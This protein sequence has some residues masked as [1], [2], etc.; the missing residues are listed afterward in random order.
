MRTTRSFREPPIMPGPVGRALAVG[1]MLVALS[2]APARGADDTALPPDEGG[3]VESMGQPP[4]FLPYGGLSRW[5]PTGRRDAADVAASG[6]LH[7]GVF[8]P[9]T[10]PIASIG[11]AGEAYLGA[12]G[13]AVDGGVRALGVLRPLGF[14]IGIDYS[15]AGN[16]PDLIVSFQRSFKRGGLF[17]RG[18]MFRL[19][20]LPTRDHTFTIGYQ[21]PL[22][23]SWMGRTRPKTDRVKLLE[24]RGE[25][26]ELASRREDAALADA[27]ARVRHAA[28][29]QSRCVAPFLD[30]HGDTQA[31]GSRPPA[32]ENPLLPGA[33]G[34]DGC[35][36][37]GR[38]QLSG[39]D[40]RLPRRSSTAP[41]PS[42]RAAAP[43]VGRP[44][45]AARRG[46][47]SRRRR[48]RS[49]STR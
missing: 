10:S 29:W 4:R 37:P 23:D 6:T 32:R 16:D 15:I 31:G 34:R 28:E 39:G 26:R 5:V 35:R 46:A 24:P 43:R 1:S 42:P 22:G 3:E 48:A 40:P 18:G 21:I 30:Q 36:L 7:V 13:S 27:L 25:C 49:C 14:G 41:S 45:R 9:L 11:I 2:S 44:A 8:K 17:G 47:G 33:R 12:R 20:Y 19:N 38:T